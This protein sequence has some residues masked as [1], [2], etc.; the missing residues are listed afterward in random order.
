MKAK[1]RT[2]PIAGSRSGQA[3][4]EYALVL[5]FVSVVAVCVLMFMGVQMNGV[6]QTIIDALDRVRTS[7]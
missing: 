1:L 4:V 6:Y 3:L 2:N 5:A 7:I